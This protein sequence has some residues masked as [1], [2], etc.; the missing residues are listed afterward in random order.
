MKYLAAAIAFAV[1]VFAML[2]RYE[3]IYNGANRVD[4]LT[5]SVQS[6]CGYHTEKQYWAE[7]CDHGK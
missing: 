1:V 3:Y 5:G 6:L 4:R 7:D 2:N